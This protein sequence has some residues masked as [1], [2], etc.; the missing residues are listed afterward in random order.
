MGVSKNIPL[1]EN[2]PSCVR[3]VFDRELK[4][5]FFFSV[6]TPAHLGKGVGGIVRELDPLQDGIVGRTVHNELTVPQPRDG[7]ER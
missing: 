2:Y 7:A 1:R 5:F 3:A 4:F 6:Y